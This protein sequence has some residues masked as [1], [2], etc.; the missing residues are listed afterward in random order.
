MTKL[1]REE[2]EQIV[3]QDLPGYKMSEETIR[4]DEGYGSRDSSGNSKAIEQQVDAVTPDIDALRMKYLQNQYLGTDSDSS[5]S[6]G[7]TAD[8]EYESGLIGRVAPGEDS[9]EDEIIAVQSESSAHPWDRSA[10]PKAAV[11]SGK[12]K[13]VIGQQG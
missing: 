1:L 4:E 8:E 9:P 3:S 11:I 12:E 7:I 5:G 13:K 6:Y 10:R 2:L